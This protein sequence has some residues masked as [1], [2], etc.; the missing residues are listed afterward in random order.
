MIVVCGT[1]YS[2]SGALLDLL[3]EIDGYFITPQE[4]RLFDDPDGII[5]LESALVDNWNMFQADMALNRYLRLCKN[6]YKKNLGNYSVLEYK[7]YFGK[8]FLLYAENYIK[9]L[10]TITY[11]GLWYGTDSYFQRKLNRLKIFQRS[12]ATT[13][14][15]YISDPFT[16]KEFVQKTKVF[17][18][19]IS[20]KAL[21]L[22]NKHEIVFDTGNAA[23]N[24]HRILPY[25]PEKSKIILVVRDPRDIYSQVFKSGAMFLPDKLSQFAKLQMAFYKRYKEIKV[26]NNK[27]LMVLK[28]EDLICHYDKKLKDILTFLNL[29]YD[30]HTQKSHFLKPEISIK[31]IGLWKQKLNNETINYLDANL[32]EILDEFNY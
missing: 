2:G 25:L 12:F 16:H 13:K 23:F 8:E 20:S 21:E 29:P 6:L 32:R 17:I 1:G 19:N 15:M 18:N 11:K 30:S 9:D 4:F 24:M 7:Q 22:A 5:S 10:S 26:A 28:F 31:N 27:K 14:N 3:K